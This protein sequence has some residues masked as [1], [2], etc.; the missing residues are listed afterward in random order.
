VALVFQI[1]TSS[2]VFSG[3][4]SDCPKSLSDEQA[5][6]V[7][8]SFLEKVGVE[9]AGLSLRKN[10]CTCVEGRPCI[11]QIE[12]EDF[13]L[14]VNPDSGEVC[15]FHARSSTI[16]PKTPDGR[17]VDASVFERELVS[18][19]HSEAK[20]KARDFLSS[21]YGS[22]VVRNLVLSHTGTR[23]SGPGYY[24]A[25]VWTNGP[26]DQG[27]REGDVYFS[28]HV[29]P[30]D[31]R[32]S[33]ASLI[34]NRV[35]MTPTLDKAKVVEVANAVLVSSSALDCVDLKDVVLTQEASGPRVGELVWVLS[36]SGPCPGD[37]GTTRLT[38][39]VV[40][41]RDTTG[42]ATTRSPSRR[43]SDVQTPPGG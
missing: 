3:F 38:H 29:N 17:S 4:A 15:G 2:A 26:N 39:I 22:D 27:Y 32:V 8:S 31:G 37:D 36:F 7:A 34:R 11:Q 28:V 40:D 23:I 25:F 1:S 20:A 18:I 12:V 13:W 6:N 19:S 35:H 5:L 16:P 30:I 10:Q 41:V 9:G 24:Y 21:V 33:D 42:E 43:S 14:L